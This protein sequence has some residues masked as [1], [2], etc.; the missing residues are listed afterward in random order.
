VTKA[1]PPPPPKP[2][3]GFHSGCDVSPE[4]ELVLASRPAR[5]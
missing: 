5:Q 1:I 4:Q 3:A 2:A